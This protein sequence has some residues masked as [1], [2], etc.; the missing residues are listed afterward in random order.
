MSF[1][2]TIKILITLLLSI[3]GV[4]L[5]YNIFIYINS[6]IKFTYNIKRLKHGILNIDDI[7]DLTPNEFE[8][9]CGDF[10]KKQG[11]KDVYVTPKSPD[12]GKDIV[13][14]KNNKKYYVECKK[15][16]NSR[17]AK[18]KVTKNICKKLV[19]AMVG[20]GIAN[21][22]IITTGIFTKD[23]LEYIN[24]LPAQYDFILYDG[25]DL[26]SEYESF[27]SLSFIEI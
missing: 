14:E 19:G 4:N 11:F 1:L 26:I 18:F 25:K 7:H 2:N 15:Y 17:N 20:D 13:C 27:R 3:Y 8:H 12:E 21:G 16:A 5:V 9:W 23:S 6:R 24:T 22:I 10:L